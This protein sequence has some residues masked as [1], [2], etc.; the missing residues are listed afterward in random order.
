MV[1]IL[2]A[3]LW[4]AAQAPDPPG[5]PRK[6]LR[7]RLLERAQKGEA[8]AQFELAKDYEGGRIGLPQDL[9]QAQH[10]YREAANQG[11]PFAEA[12]LGIMYNV[13]KGVPRDPVLAYVWLDR[14]ISHM[15][16]AERDTVVEM[17]ESVGRKMTAGQLADARRMSKERERASKQ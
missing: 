15:T 1:L 10:W 5:A 9:A 11:E 16:G 17:R 13:G 4:F 12:S 8:E 3:I 6:P 2:A 14:A 7:E